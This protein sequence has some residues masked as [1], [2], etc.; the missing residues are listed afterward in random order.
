MKYL[1]DSAFAPPEIKQGFL[2]PERL[3]TGFGQFYDA[4]A[5][6]VAANRKISISNYVDL[7]KL[8]NRTVANLGPN[9]PGGTLLYA[10]KRGAGKRFCENGS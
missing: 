10:F 9:D 7:R 6:L 1:E 3:K 8:L 2:E 5:K 4:Y